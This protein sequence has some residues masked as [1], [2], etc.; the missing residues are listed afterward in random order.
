LSETP[1]WRIEPRP[2][3]PRR[4]LFWISLAAFALWVSLLAWVYALQFGR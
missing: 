2:L 4:G 3:T 1:T